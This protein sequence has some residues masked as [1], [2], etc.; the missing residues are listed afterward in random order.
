M[1]LIQQIKDYIQLQRES[2]AF[3]SKEIN[4]F[5]FYKQG[6]EKQ[7]KRASKQ[8]PCDQAWQYTP[9]ILVLKRQR[10]ADLC[11]SK[12]SLAYTLWLPG[13]PGL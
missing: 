8:C 4:T 5:S 7:S 11:E 2:S 6:K 3:L 9:E 1:I 10:L 12:G 13:Q